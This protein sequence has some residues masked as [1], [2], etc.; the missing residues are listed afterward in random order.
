VIGL[1]ASNNDHLN[2]SHSQNH[3]EAPK[4]SRLTQIYGQRKSSDQLPFAGKICHSVPQNQPLWD[5][6]EILHGQ[7]QPAAQNQIWQ[8]TPKFQETP[9][10]LVT[11]ST[12]NWLGQRIDPPSLSEESWLHKKPDSGKTPLSLT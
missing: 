1:E 12:P 6:Q 9:S 3:C 10:R 2:Q 11:S 8:Q 7:I 5:G 4:F